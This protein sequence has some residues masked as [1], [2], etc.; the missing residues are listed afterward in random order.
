MTGNIIG[1][2]LDMGGQVFALV[3]GLMDVRANLLRAVSLDVQN[4]Y[5]RIAAREYNR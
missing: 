3:I 2:A 4:D 5:E 1:M